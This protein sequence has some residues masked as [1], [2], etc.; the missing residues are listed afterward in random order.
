MAKDTVTGKGDIYNFRGDEKFRE[1]I[2]D[3]RALY[4]NVTLSEALQRG[5]SDRV[6]IAKMLK[7]HDMRSIVESG[8][9]A[10]V[11]S[12]FTQ[13]LTALIA[14][15]DTFY[16]T[17]PDWRTWLYQHG[18]FSALALRCTEPGK[19]TILFM[20]FNIWNEK[21]TNENMDT[22]TE[23]FAYCADQTE[24]RVPHLTVLGIPEPLSD[25]II[26]TERNCIY[27]PYAL[28]PLL[29]LLFI[30][31]TP[32]WWKT[33]NI[34]KGFHA[35][36]KYFFQALKDIGTQVEFHDNRPGKKRSPSKSVPKQSR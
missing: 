17:T 29:G 24:N 10:A 11:Q 18:H 35:N 3:L 9:S 30:P 4:P 1:V 6:K 26:Y 19:E 36:L 7:Y 25:T 33:K 12:P 5:I 15:A 2:S 28:A 20:P 14:V 13:D 27:N 22:V 8:L 21:Q 16:M 32:L 31:E 23:L 34:E